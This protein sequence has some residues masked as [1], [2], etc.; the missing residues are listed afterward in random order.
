MEN[1]FKINVDWS[2]VQLK[3]IQS[4]PNTIIKGP[5]GSGKT[6]LAL[7]KAI[8]Y[9]E[10]GKSTALI[11]FTKS[12]RTFIKDFFIKKGIDKVNVFY[13]REWSLK[14]SKAYD[15][16]IID[17]FQDFSIE[18]IQSIIAKANEGVFIFGDDEQKLYAKNLNKEKTITLEQLVIQT[19]FTVI[20]LNINYRIPKQIVDLINDIYTYTEGKKISEIPVLNQILLHLRRTYNKKSLSNYRTNTEKA[21]VKQF[22]DSSEQLEWLSQFLVTN[23]VYKNIGVLFKQNDSKSND[24]VSDGK[25]KEERLPGILETFNYLNSNGIVLGYKYYNEDLLNFKEKTNINLLT[26]HSAK[27]LEFDCVILP[28]YSLKN[29]NYNMNIPYVA[30]S[31]CTN[32][33]IILYSGSISQEL[34]S[35]NKSIIEE[36]IFT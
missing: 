19:K 17:E 12:L 9:S 24:Y 5:A 31:R 29:K 22:N 14:F 15:I 21:E 34:N 32:R 4:L 30:F 25:S 18:D 8:Y 6:L 33:L 16:I 28:F 7:Y 13:E 10:K 2:D 23:E 3:V 26:V 27:G 36:T 1:Q 35:I 20:Y 11:V